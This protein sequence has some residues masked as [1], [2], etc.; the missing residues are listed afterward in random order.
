MH[1]RATWACRKQWIVQRYDQDLVANP[2]LV[3]DVIAFIEGPVA[4]ESEYLSRNLRQCLQLYVRPCTVHNRRSI[5]A[6]S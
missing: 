2:K 4:R 6:R 3:N 5:V 1:G